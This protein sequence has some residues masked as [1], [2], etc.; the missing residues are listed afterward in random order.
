MIRRILMPLCI[1]V[2]LAITAC[3]GTTDKE[4]NQKKN[5]PK[6]ERQ[7]ALP[8]QGANSPQ[9]ASN[10]THLASQTNWRVNVTND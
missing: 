8:F 7:A 5:P 10:S 9:S 4:P 1:C 3:G 2:A 6:Q